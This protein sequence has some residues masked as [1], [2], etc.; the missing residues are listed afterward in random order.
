MRD[1]ERCPPW[2]RNLLRLWKKG[3][4]ECKESASYLTRLRRSWEALRI[5]EIVSP[6]E[7]ILSIGDAISVQARIFLDDLKPEELGVELYYGPLSSQGE[8]EEPRRLEMSPCGS[9]GKAALFCANVTCDRTGRQGYTV[10]ILPKHPSL[11]HP[12]LPGLVKWG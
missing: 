6:S 9:A 1:K 10:R 8:I 3:C 2:N 11:V 4:A 7:R 12:F 5:E